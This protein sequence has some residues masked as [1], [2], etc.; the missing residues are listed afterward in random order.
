MGVSYTSKTWKDRDVQYPG[1]RQLQKADSS[2]EQVTVYRDEGTI[3]EVGDGFNAANMNDLEGRIGTA[4]SAVP[5]FVELT[6]GLLAGNTTLQLADASITT[7]S[8]FDIFTDIYGVS[9]TA[10]TVA[11]GS[12]TLTFEAQS[13]GMQVKVRVW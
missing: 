4:F 10:V 1:R 5:T 13:V 8:T 6:G 12:I 11:T 9:P 3:T 2:T 7:G